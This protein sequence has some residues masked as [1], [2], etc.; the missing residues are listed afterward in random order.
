MIA[1]TAAA[2][3]E[4]NDVTPEQPSIRGPKLLRTALCGFDDGRDNRGEP[5]R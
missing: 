2:A 1:K 4:K 5:A 3:L